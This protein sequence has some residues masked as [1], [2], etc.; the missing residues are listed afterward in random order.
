MKPFL[1]K[2]LWSW[3]F[4]NS[5]NTDTGKLL[6]FQQ[7]LLLCCKLY[8]EV[9]C[10]VTFCFC[11]WPNMHASFKL[12]STVSECSSCLVLLSRYLY[13]LKIQLREAKVRRVSFQNWDRNCVIITTHHTCWRIG[14]QWSFS[15][16]V[17]YWPAVVL[18]LRFCFHSSPP[19]CP[20]STTRP[21]SPWSPVDCDF[22][23]GVGIL[24]QH[25]P[26]ELRNGGLSTFS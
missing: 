6:L 5:L 23:D 7:L 15:T 4:K 18:V 25:V 10:Y 17:C 2:Q 13:L 3:H 1:L 19:G 11:G 20:K 8:G 21:L 12:M 22:C 14:Q 16:R 9:D 26:K 24:S